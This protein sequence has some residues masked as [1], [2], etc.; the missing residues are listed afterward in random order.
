MANAAPA[1]SKKRLVLERTTEDGALT[2]Q[3]VAKGE[4]DLDLMLS[5]DEDSEGICLARDV[6]GVE[7]VCDI[8]DDLAEC[9]QKFVAGEQIEDEEEEAAEGEVDEEEEEGA[10]TE[11]EEEVASE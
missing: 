7:E 11:E 8:L 3:L 10:E 1:R 5:D 9:V 4:N 6:A 2:F